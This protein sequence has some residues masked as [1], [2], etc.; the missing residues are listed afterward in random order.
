M[1]TP[2][3]DLT[4]NDLHAKS[5][6]AD[7]QPNPTAESVEALDTLASAAVK[8]KAPVEPVKPVAPVRPVETS[9]EKAA[10]EA[11]KAEDDKAAAAAA[12][13][14]DTPEEK[15]AKEAAQAEADKAA[16][17]AA[18]AADPFSAVELPPNS[19]PRSVEAFDKVKDIARS[20]V[21]EV[22]G[23]LTEASNT[24]TK[25]T[26]QLEELKKGQGKLSP[27]LEAEVAALRQFKVSQDI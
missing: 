22:A 4:P 25:L 16:A 9:E 3:T 8:A 18:A 20:K 7:L 15:A 21:A 27:E 5:D 1:A 26:S 2:V 6:E 13:H 11:A 19:K 23:K 12:S 14:E 10:K 24:I 17:A